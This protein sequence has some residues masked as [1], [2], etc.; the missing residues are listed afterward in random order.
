MK[1]GPNFSRAKIVANEVLENNR[2]DLRNGIISP[3]QV[4]AQAKNAISERCSA[5]KCFMA[6][7]HEVLIP[8]TI[9]YAKTAIISAQVEQL[10]SAGMSR[11][12]AVNVAWPRKL[13]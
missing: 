13:S 8:S 7:V 4:G 6:A 2:D 3:E 5:E 11:E 10:M 9:H 1:H 12:E